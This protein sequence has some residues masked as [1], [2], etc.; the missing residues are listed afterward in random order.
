LDKSKAQVTDLGN[1]ISEVKWDI[2]L[3]NNG[4]EP[5]KNSQLTDITSNEAFDVKTELALTTP[6]TLFKQIEAGNSHTCVVDL[7]DKA[8]CWGDGY[9]GKLGNGH[10]GY[11]YKKATPTAV[12]MPAGVN[13]SQIATGQD[14]TCALDSDSQA[15]CWGRGESGELG[16]GYS[17]IWYTE[18]T[19]TAVTMPAGV[20]FSQIT[21]GS[22]HTCTLGS[23]NQTYCWGVGLRGQLGNGNSGS[24]YEETAPTA[25]TMPTGVTFS[26]IT[27]GQEHTCALGSDNQAYCWGRGGG[28][29]GNGTY[30]SKSTPT[31]VTMPA[32]VTFSQIVA[33][34]G[35]TCALGSDNQ[36][37]CWGDGEH[38][39]LGN[40]TTSD[41]LSPT[42]VTMPTGVT[43]SQ[44]AAGWGYTCALGSDSQTYCWG[45]GSFGKLGNG[46]TDNKLT[47][48]AVTM[49]TGAIFNQITAGSGHT[50]ALDSDNQAYC[51]GKG[52]YGKL[53]NGTEDDKLTPTPVQHPIELIS[54]ADISPSSSNPGATTTERTYSFGTVYPGERLVVTMT[55]K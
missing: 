2:V 51:W 36:A 52:E 49:P 3:E 6:P 27:A 55:A 11:N 40:G 35:H 10:S 30:G 48:T 41:K 29:L 28:R 7:N 16:N 33:G 8:Y 45:D 13:F 47:P 4:N 12:A 54:S 31:A 46:T 18:D 32:G 21:V 14:H 17:A 53:G 19:P 50:C 43:F 34:S 9:H 23:D 25:V 44:I 26:Q 24:G 38:G 5:L 39:Q 1:G 42:A 22:W 15:Y 20:T 37:Y